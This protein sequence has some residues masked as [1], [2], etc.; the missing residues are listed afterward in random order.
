MKTTK[1]AASRHPAKSSGNGRSPWLAKPRRMLIDGKW[2]SAASGETFPTFDPATGE[3]ICDVPSGGKADIDR[4][5][6]AAR[7]A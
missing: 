1:L 2:V 4:A 5:V 3:V 7:A 6:K